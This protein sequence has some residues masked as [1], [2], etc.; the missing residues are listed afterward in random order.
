VEKEAAALRPLA[1]IIQH[2]KSHPGHNANLISLAPSRSLLLAGV[3]R[4]EEMASSLYAPNLEDYLPSESDS[5][6]QEP[7]R[8]LN[9]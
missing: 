8:S 5:P 1:E 9:L 7:P 3:G 4:W 2:L 6:P